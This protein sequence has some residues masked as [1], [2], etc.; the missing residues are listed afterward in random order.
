MTQQ[1]RFGPLVGWRFILFGPRD[2]CVTI[3]HHWYLFKRLTRVSAGRLYRFEQI[4]THSSFKALSKQRDIKMTASFFFDNGMCM[5]CPGSGTE[6]AQ[7]K[8]QG[9]ALILQAAFA[10]IN[11]AKG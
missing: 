3:G 10:D 4:A 11:I 6:R 5:F 2:I 1:S 8:T 7:P 9:S